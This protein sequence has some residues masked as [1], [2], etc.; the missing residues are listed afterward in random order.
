[1]V[2][3]VG[4]TTGHSSLVCLQKYTHRRV[5]LQAG[6]GCNNLVFSVFF[7]DMGTN[8]LE[9]P[10]KEDEVQTQEPAKVILFNDDVHTFEEVIT[11]LIKAIRCTSQEA[12]ALA[13]EVHSVGKAAVY[14]ACQVGAALVAAV[15]L[16]EDRE[17]S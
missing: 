15:M 7:I 3:P 11:Q 10:E 14:M 13:W 12:E 16:F 2:N 5:S 17:L 6:T 4:G 1:M 8:P 9:Q